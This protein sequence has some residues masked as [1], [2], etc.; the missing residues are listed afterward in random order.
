MLELTLDAEYHFDERQGRLHCPR[1]GVVFESPLRPCALDPTAVARYSLRTLFTHWHPEGLP[2]SQE[3]LLAS[4]RNYRLPEVQLELF[5]RSSL[6]VVHLLSYLEQFDP[7]LVGFLSGLPEATLNM[8]MA[9]QTSSELGEL[10]LNNPALAIALL[11]GLGQAGKAN[12]IARRAAAR[13]RHRDLLVWLGFPSS[14]RLP[15]LLRDK[16]APA[17]LTGPC[18]KTVQ[19]LVCADDTPAELLRQLHAPLTPAGFAL[20]RLAPCFT[21]LPFSHDLLEAVDAAWREA[22]PGE[23]SA[24]WPHQQL[25]AI[26][27]A[28]RYWCLR[29]QYHCLETLRDE[30]ERITLLT[31]LAQGNGDSFAGG[32]REDDAELPLDRPAP[33]PFEDT[34]GINALSQ[35]ELLALHGMHQSNC[36]AHAPFSFY[37]NSW[38]YVYGVYDERGRSIATLQ[39]TRRHD[40]W[41]V[42]E[43]S[44][45]ANTEPQQEVVA[46]VDR[47]CTRH[48]VLPAP[49]ESPDDELLY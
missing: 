24:P 27:A 5:D 49:I 23:M 29:T 44:G 21:T 34:D 13:L 17:V 33:P 7:R 9:L 32:F 12:N 40:L 31:E 25:E 45:K 26:L 4:A 8:L 30:Y 3:A 6:G 43:L 15:A 36:L 19:D 11:S 16:L 42:S 47:W 10:A 14:T 18:L 38:R 35:P 46:R 39:I 37:C 20:L 22:H 41:F 48:T 1:S 2:A 28:P